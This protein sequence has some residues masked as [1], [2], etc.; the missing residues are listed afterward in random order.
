[1]VD[2][3]EDISHVSEYMVYN[4]LECS[5]CICESHWHNQELKGAI[6][7]SKA[8]LPL[9]ASCDANIVIASADQDLCISSCH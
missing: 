1:M 5:G 9:M 8:C 4:G 2:H 6:M 7:G 3:Y